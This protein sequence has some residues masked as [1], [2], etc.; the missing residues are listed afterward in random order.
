ML[1]AGAVLLTASRA[2]GGCL[3]NTIGTQIFVTCEPAETASG[4]RGGD[5]D[6]AATGWRA[7]GSPDSRPAIRRFEEVGSRMLEMEP[8]TQIRM[9]KIR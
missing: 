6:G 1:V 3:I 7:N 4:W 5:E 9:L 2:L 8:N